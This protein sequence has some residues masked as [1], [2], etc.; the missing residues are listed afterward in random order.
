MV[1]E[2]YRLAQGKK[3]SA[4]VWHE[5]NNIHLKRDGFD[6]K[7]VFK[8]A[9]ETIFKVWL[10]TYEESN[11]LNNIGKISIPKEDIEEFFQNVN[12]PKP[13]RKQKIN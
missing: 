3:L 11:H 1:V 12:N 6:E 8:D 13:I 4:L 5:N 10:K 7:I 2:A 9:N